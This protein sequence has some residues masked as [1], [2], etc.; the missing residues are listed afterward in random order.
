MGQVVQEIQDIKQKAERSEEL[1][2]SMCKDIKSLDIAKRNLTFSITAL[3]KFNMMLSALEKLREN[4]HS[5]KYKDI[6]MLLE[7]IDD[8]G[9]YFKK[10]YYMPIS[11]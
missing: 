7:A 8:L 10:L 11:F 4:C 5:K 1:V 9:H 6:A 3:K 2:Y